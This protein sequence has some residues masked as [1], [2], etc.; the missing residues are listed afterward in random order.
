V[1]VETTDG[2]VDFTG[3][4]EA[5]ARVRLSTHDG[6]VTATIPPGS[7]VDVSVSTFDGSFEPSMPVVTRGLRAG[8]ALDFRLG[9]GGATLSMQAFDGDIRLRHG[10]GP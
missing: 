5:G 7:D 2:D 8:E 1:A 4:L 3:R 6:D 9:R 10:G